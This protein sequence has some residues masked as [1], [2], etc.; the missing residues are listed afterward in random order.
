MSVQ[1][2]CRTLKILYFADKL[3]LEKYGRFICGET[4]KAMTSGPCPTGTYSLIQ[5][6]AE[7]QAFNTWTNTDF[8]IERSYTIHPLRAPDLG[9]LSKSDIEC[10]DE[11]IKHNKHLTGYQ[12]KA[13]SHDKAYYSVELNEDIPIFNIAQTL[14][15]ADALLKHLYTYPIG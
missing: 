6:K 15:N 11:A 9:E 1:N 3:H 5:E 4:Y 8:K 12:L 7:E 14:L 13:K 2:Y 10:L